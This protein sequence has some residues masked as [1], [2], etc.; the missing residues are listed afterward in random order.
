M[1]R[2]ISQIEHKCLAL[3][4]GKMFEMGTFVLF[5]GAAVDFFGGFA[6]DARAVWYEL[7]SG[8]VGAGRASSYVAGM[9][10]R[11]SCPS[12]DLL[13]KMAH[14]CGYRLDL[15][16]YDGSESIHIDGGGAD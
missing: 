9:L 3:M 16:P 1:L 7:V 5:G 11:G 12:A 6:A 2:M 13:A 10:R 15:V 8:R 4:G 14:I